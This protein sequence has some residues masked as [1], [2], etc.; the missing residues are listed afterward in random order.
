MLA[1]LLAAFSALALLLAAIGVYGVLAYLVVE[2]RRE[3]AIRV[4]LG[5]ARSRVFRDVAR[6]GIVLVGTGVAVGAAVAFGLSRLMS[7]LLFGVGTADLATYAG[8]AGTVGVV[9]A[10]ACGVPA[11]RATR[12]DPA[13]VFRAD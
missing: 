11:W 5:A 3:I 7:S 9:A 4:A 12:L 10:V 2:R 13:V 1:W 8:A 6:Q